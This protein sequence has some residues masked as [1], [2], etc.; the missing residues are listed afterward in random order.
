MNSLVSID[1]I[2]GVTGI[3]GRTQEIDLSATDYSGIDGKPF[4]VYATGA[5]NI[6]YQEMK[7]PTSTNL[8]RA[9]MA[10]EILNIDGSLVGAK[11]VVRT[12]TTATGLRAIYF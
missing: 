3:I 9:V 10:D 4:L 2:V 5:G 6:V 7:D 12:G 1:N 8:T 11:T